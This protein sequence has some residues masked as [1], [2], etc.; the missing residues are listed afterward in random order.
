MTTVAF[1]YQH[2]R[3]PPLCPV[4]YCIKAVAKVSPSCGLPTKL[5]MSTTTL[6]PDKLATETLLPNSYFLCAFPLAIQLT[7]GAWRLYTLF[8]SPLWW[9]TIRSMICKRGAY[10]SSLPNLINCLRRS[11]T[12]RPAMVLSFF[13]ARLAFLAC[14]AR[15]A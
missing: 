6:L 14:L 5:V 15:C 7:S 9:R 11:R 8:L 13:K 2:T 4:R 3:I 12:W 1:V 10:S